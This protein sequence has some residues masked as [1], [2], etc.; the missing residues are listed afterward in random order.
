[1]NRYIVRERNERI[2]GDTEVTLRQLSKPA[3]MDDC[4][5]GFIQGED[6]KEAAKNDED[7]TTPFAD[8]INLL[9]HQVVRNTVA[10][11]V[12][13]KELLEKLEECFS[14]EEGETKCAETTLEEYLQTWKKTSRWYPFTAKKPETIRA[15]QLFQEVIG[16]YMKHRLAEA[17][18][19]Q[20]MPKKNKRKQEDTPEDADLSEFFPLKRPRTEEEN[21][22]D[23]IKQTLRLFIEPLPYDGNTEKDWLVSLGRLLVYAVNDEQKPLCQALYR[24]FRYIS[25]TA[26][27][28]PDGVREILAILRWTWEKMPSFSSIKKAVDETT[29][30]DHWSDYHH[31]RL[32]FLLE[33]VDDGLAMQKTRG[34]RRVVADYMLEELQA[35]NWDPPPA[36]DVDTVARHVWAQFQDPAKRA[37]AVYLVESLHDRW[38]ATDISMHLFS[39]FVGEDLQKAN[40]RLHTHHSM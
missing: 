27:S 10:A 33:C 8:A 24:A 40:G 3:T 16:I 22:L 32:E 31:N 20:C 30:P 19:P 2:V 38:F 1:M 17:S 11:H 4:I 29:K 25:M 21:N 14:Q 13:P 9:E 36:G 26:G 7:A 35:K 5:R 15:I 28:E 6:E 18:L 12:F 23:T 39:N 37:M 34:F